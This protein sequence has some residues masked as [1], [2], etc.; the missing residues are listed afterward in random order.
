MG[1]D[2]VQAQKQAELKSFH[3]PLPLPALNKTQSMIA[4]WQ[5]N[6]MHIK[7]PNSLLLNYLSPHDLLQYR[8]VSRA[9]LEETKK[10][11]G[12][13]V[14]RRIFTIAT[15]GI[16]FKIGR[17]GEE[18]KKKCDA[19]WIVYCI[20]ILH[21]EC[22]GHSVIYKM[23]KRRLKAKEYARGE[24]I[25]KQGRVYTPGRPEEKKHDLDVNLVWTLAQIHAERSIV[26]L[27]SITAENL[28]RYDFPEQYSAFA[29][30]LGSFYKA[31]YRVSGC[32]LNNGCLILSPTL[33]KSNQLK[34]LTIYDISTNNVDIESAFNNFC[35]HNK[36]TIMF[37]LNRAV[38]RI[39]SFFSRIDDDFYLGI[40]LL[41]YREKYNES[42]R[43]LLSV[44][45][46]KEHHLFACE[47]FI[48]LFNQNSP[49]ES[50][51]QFPPSS[52][53]LFDKSKLYPLIKKHILSMIN[54][55]IDAA[56]ERMYS[57]SGVESVEEA[58]YE[59]RKIGR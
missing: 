54:T 13:Y 26:V 32:D 19:G 14:S 6:K 50:I 16:F 20:T 48:L 43:D 42:L 21:M 39:K 36:K 56:F 18:N 24:N 45:K 22:K 27:S 57:P 34:Q 59:I 2:R 47:Q 35:E 11:E 28:M 51:I 12:P 40:E 52:N 49:V 10:I 33:I 29:K 44:L 55:K 30:E 31:G 15:S 41:K 5:E 46:I 9:T 8:G 38:I 17:S 4:S 58:P 23:R 1:S 37:D 25:W 7:Y 53:G 3:F